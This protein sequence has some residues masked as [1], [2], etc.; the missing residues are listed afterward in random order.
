ML[1][2]SLKKCEF[3]LFLNEIIQF[4]FTVCVQF[5]H[6]IDWVVYK[7]HSDT[8]HREKVPAFLLTLISRSYL[9]N[10]LKGSSLYF[11]KLSDI[12]LLNKFLNSKIYF[13]IIFFPLYKNLSNSCNIYLS[14]ITSELKGKI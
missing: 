14:S 12:H 5:D 1:R 4:P 6:K 3:N 8:K 2:Q 9:L 13:N 11:F 10:T 7:E